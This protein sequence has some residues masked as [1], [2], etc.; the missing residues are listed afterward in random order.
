MRKSLDFAVNIRYTG[1]VK[2]TY[3]IVHVQGVNKERK[4][5]VSEGTYA[6]VAFNYP[7]ITLSD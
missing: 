3:N 2:V 4:C 1:I 5:T 6:S 7:D